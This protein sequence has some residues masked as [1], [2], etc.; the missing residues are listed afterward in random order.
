MCNGTVDGVD[1]VFEGA[2]D[3]AAFELPAAVALHGVGFA[4]TGLPV[5]EDGAIVALEYA[6]D[7]GEGGLFEDYFL[8]AAGLEGHIEAE[9]SFLFSDIFLVVHAYFSAFRRDID[10]GLVVLFEFVGGEGS[11]ADC[12][13]DAFSFSHVI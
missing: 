12:D 9:D 4:G 1:D 11:A 8:E 7:D 13:L 2:R 5:C 6:F 10:D 3:D